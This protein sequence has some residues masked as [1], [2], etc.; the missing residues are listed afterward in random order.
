MG[1]TNLVNG[2]ADGN[3]AI[4]TTIG[5]IDTSGSVAIGIVNSGP[6][7]WNQ[8]EGSQSIAGN[9]GQNGRNNGLGS[10]NGNG[11]GAGNGNGNN[12]GNGGGVDNG[13]N[14]GNLNG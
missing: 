10:G 4:G 2:T 5:N 13:N 1:Q 12:N 7:N 8:A 6:R 14:N 11:G 3:T 9:G